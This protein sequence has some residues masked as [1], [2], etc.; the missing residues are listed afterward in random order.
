MQDESVLTKPKWKLIFAMMITSILPLIDG[1][2]VNVILPVVAY[3]I[4]CTNAHI[5]WAVII[6]MLSCVAGMLLYPFLH[7]KLGIRASWYI[8]LLLFLTGSVFSGLSYNLTLLIVSRFVQGA[9]A[10][11]MIPLAQS[12]LVLTFSKERIKFVMGLIAVP[13]VFSPAIGPLLG[14]FFTEVIS[15]RVSFLINI[16]VIILSVWFGKNVIPKH[17][18]TINGFNYTAYLLF[19]SS[20]VMVFYSLEMIN[21]EGGVNVRILL[22]LIGLGV[23]LFAIGVVVNNK[24]KYKL[25]SFSQFTSINYTFSM[26]MVFFTSLVF[27]SFMIFFPLISSSEG[28]GNV[29]YL[30]LLLSL[31]GVGA[32][33]S[34]RF[35]YN[36]LNNSSSLRVVSAG[37]LASAFSVLIISHGTYLYDII[38]FTFRGLALGAA[39]IA[40]LSAPYEWT[41][42]IFIKDTSTIIRIIQQLGGAF[43]SLLAGWLLYGIAIKL[44]TVEYAYGVFIIGSLF[45]GGGAFFINARLSIRR[46]L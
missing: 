33:V 30:G 5:Q 40:V 20:L 37:L 23:F 10:G 38:G 15:W 16:P 35:F 29:L 14:A 44:F 3:D 31:Q 32:W 24:S 4:G 42:K 17:N 26:I 43:G 39:T 7:D 21:H 45:I 1:S 13:A 6:Y 25:I 18:H 9:G 2:I 36:K 41:N 27:Y 11:I 46:N 19:L 12:I 28:K 8:S 22:A 34:R